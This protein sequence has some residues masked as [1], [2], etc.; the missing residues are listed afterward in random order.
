M[1]STHGSRNELRAVT[2]LSLG[3]GLVGVDRFL[4]STMYP[5]IARD[6]HLGY[7]DIGTITGALAIAW[8]AAA[9]VMGNVSDHVG[10]RRV[11]AGSLIVFSLLIGASG[12]A[13]GLAGLVLVRVVMGFA[14]GAYTPA[15]I[16]ATIHQSPP[17]RHGRN[18]GL[19]QSMLVLFGLG[20]SP[21]LVGWLLRE[22]MDWRYIFSLFVLPGLILA[23]KTWAIIPDNRRSEVSERNSFADWG[24]VLKYRNIR[25]LMGGMLCW[26]T[27]LITCSAF[28]PSYF[29]DHLQL[30][31]GR[32]GTVMSA[33][34]FG[35]MVGTI[36]L[37]AASDRFGRKPV[38]L[39]CSLVT[40]AGL[41]LLGA[42][43]PNTGLLFACLFVIHFCNN[44]LIT[45]TV[46]PVAAETV[47]S[48]LMATA[49]GVV[50]A[51]G[52]L[53]GGGLAPMVGGQ[54]A[55][56]FG[57]DH[58]LWLPILMMSIGVLL[59]AGLKE[60]RPAFDQGVTIA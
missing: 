47:P 4:I 11:L 43:G 27:C 53:F 23:W 35:A 59:C 36:V 33:I 24:A 37:S 14:D 30:D 38:M 3:F 51:T 52:E 9:L 29:V 20:L 10:Q 54:V 40:L 12:L 50:I 16:A 5:T 2:V 15:S 49:S 56:R 25:L 8:G 45:M 44:T 6:L 21:L 17:Q 7:G 31:N 32:M 46:G 13:G 41:A 18:V 55:E 28:L 57:I 42:I 19:Q 39:I 34:G 58:I 26:L 48:A 1:P 22:G 60:T